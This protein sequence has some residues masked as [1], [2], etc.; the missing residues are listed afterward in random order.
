MN[1]TILP[2]IDGFERASGCGRKARAAFRRESDK[3]GEPEGRGAGARRN[4]GRHLQ[5]TSGSKPISS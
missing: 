2:V 4:P 5:N 1:K 3:V